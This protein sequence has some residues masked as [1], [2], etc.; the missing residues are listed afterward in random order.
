MLAQSLTER[1]AELVAG[2]IAR[3]LFDASL[4]L[5][6]QSR[7]LV[8]TELRIGQSRADALQIVTQIEHPAEF[9]RTPFDFHKCL[10]IRN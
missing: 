1:T 10:L 3:Q 5:P 8:A 9:N 4:R 6:P 7:S 2:E